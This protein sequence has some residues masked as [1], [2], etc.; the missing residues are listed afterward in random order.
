[1]PAKSPLAVLLP[2]PPTKQWC[3]AASQ[4]LT[5]M[6]IATNMSHQPDSGGTYTTIPAHDLLLRP[7]AEANDIGWP[8]FEV[9]LFRGSLT[10]TIARF[11]TA[12][13]GCT[14]TGNFGFATTPPDIQSVA[15]DGVVAAKQAMGDGASSVIGADALAISPW[16]DFF[17]IGSPQRKVLD[18]YRYWGLA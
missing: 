2:P 3:A 14:I 18:S 12:Q 5:S 9:W 15:I 17:G 16:K 11:P 1:M 10:G 8:F 13:N 6:G 4:V 7:K